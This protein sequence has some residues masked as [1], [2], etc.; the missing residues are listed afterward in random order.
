ME[1]IFSF[2]VGQPVWVQ[3]GGVG[4]SEGVT[5][6]L[7]LNRKHEYIILV[8]YARGRRD[9]ERRPAQVVPRDP[10]LRGADKPPT[11]GR[12]R[13]KRCDECLG[14]GRHNDWCSNVEVEA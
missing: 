2:E 12:E 1:T 4:W 7:R 8:T 11:R 5:T 13:R 10:G 3:S 6:G 14:L 9:G